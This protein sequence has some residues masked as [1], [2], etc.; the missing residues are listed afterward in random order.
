ML[1]ASQPC[2]VGALVG[3]LV[4]AAVGLAVGLVLGDAVGAVV[5]DVDGLAVGDTDGAADGAAVGAVVG[6]AVTGTLHS[7]VSV[8]TVPLPEYPGLQVQ[9]CLPGPTCLHVDT[10]LA[11]LAQSFSDAL[12]G[13]TLSWHTLPLKP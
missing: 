10:A 5:G 11:G 9:V 13:L 8:H 3:L 6:L 7:L 1:L 12:H 4:G 2:A